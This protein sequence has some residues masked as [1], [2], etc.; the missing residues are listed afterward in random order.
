MHEVDGVKASRAGRR[1]ARLADRPRIYK[2]LYTEQDYRTL[3]KYT[4][5]YTNIPHI[6]R[7]IRRENVQT[8]LAAKIAKQLLQSRGFVF[9]GLPRSANPKNEP[10]SLSENQ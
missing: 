5:H 2:I 9:V 3:H 10:E 4:A 1:P 7:N 6:D 8:N